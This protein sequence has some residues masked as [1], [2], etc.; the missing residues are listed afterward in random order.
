MNNF[1]SK[2]NK[3]KKSN[4]LLILTIFALQIIIASVFLSNQANNDDNMDES[5]IQNYSLTFTLFFLI[6]YIVNHKIVI[7]INKTI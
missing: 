3:N 4:L 1:K 7:I 6:N 2:F 5:L